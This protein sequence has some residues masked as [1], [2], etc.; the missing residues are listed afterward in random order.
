MTITDNKKTIQ[1]AIQTFSKGSLTANSLQLFNTLGYNTE[2]QASLD[3]P[4]RQEFRE[5]YVNDNSRFNEEKAL[6]DQWKYVDLLFQLSKEEILKQTSLFDA[7]KVDRTVIET[8]LF[9][10]IE[11]EIDQSSR[12]ELANITREINKLFPMP[13]MLLF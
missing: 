10:A 8:Y 6:F 9:F 7:K 13:V 5:S 11:L 12:T 2:R 3:K 1:S 4:T